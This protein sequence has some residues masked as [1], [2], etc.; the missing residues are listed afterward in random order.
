MSSTSI[1]HKTEISCPENAIIRLDKVN[2]YNNESCRKSQ[3]Y[4]GFREKCQGKQN[5]SISS[6]EIG[7]GNYAI[8]IDYKCVA[9]ATG[10]ILGSNQINADVNIEEGTGGISI[11]GNMHSAHHSGDTEKTNDSNE[12]KTTQ[13]NSQSDNSNSTTQ[14]NLSSAGEANGEANA[15]AHESINSSD[16]NS[17]S[18]TDNDTILIIVCVVLL[19]ILLIGTGIGFYFYQKSNT[20]SS[21]M[22]MG[23]WDSSPTDSLTKFIDNM[24]L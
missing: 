2:E 9:A 13:Q 7:C 24:V 17:A 6:E 3:I 16:S 11:S 14:Q 22:M 4:S 5:C 8:D 1:L 19:C 18:N 15:V 12:E 10:D 20:E 21:Q 23:G